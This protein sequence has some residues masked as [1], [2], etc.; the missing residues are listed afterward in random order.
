MKM[1]EDSLN[2]KSMRKQDSPLSSSL[3]KNKV[4]E[5][6]IKVPTE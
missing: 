1:S 2:P 3:G 5:K 6:S 4:R